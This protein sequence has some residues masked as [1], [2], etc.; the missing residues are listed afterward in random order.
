MKTH[1]TRVRLTLFGLL[2][3]ALG[4]DAASGDVYRYHEKSSVVDAD[5]HFEDT[6]GCISTSVF[7]HVII[8]RERT[9]IEDRTSGV[10]DLIR[11][12]SCAGDQILLRVA[13]SLTPTPEEMNFQG[14]LDS[15]TF[16]TTYTAKDVV[17]GTPRTVHVNLFW[18]ATD[19]AEQ[20]TRRVSNYTPEYRVKYQEHGISRPAQATGSIIVDGEEMILG[21]SSDASMTDSRMRVMEIYD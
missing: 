9:A 4:S 3:L 18:T 12:N 19:R 20:T 5:F 16:I 7:V 11:T 10:V 1:S 6:S 15:A 21:P 17:S 14:H 8:D 2:A 13:T